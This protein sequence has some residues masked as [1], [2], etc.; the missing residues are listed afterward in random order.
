MRKI[1]FFYDKTY[2]L[3]LRDNI[4]ISVQAFIQSLQFYQIPN[5]ETR[6]I[7]L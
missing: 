5:T 4:C 2:T 6:D 1:E 7:I 3:M